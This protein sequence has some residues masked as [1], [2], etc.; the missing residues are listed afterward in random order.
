M[1]NN[2]SQ[3]KDIIESILLVSSEPVACADLEE[4]LE[5]ENK[6]L[7]A[8]ALDELENEYRLRDRGFFLQRLGD[9]VRLVTK[10]E[11]ALWIRRFLAGKPVRFSRAALETLA[12]IAYR[13]PITRP[14]IEA[15]RG[16]DASGVLR[17]LLARELIAI[18]G[19]KE[20]P[21]SPWMYVTTDKFLQVF[22][23]ASLSSLPDINSFGDLYPSLELPLLDGQ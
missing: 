16:V 19:R 23:L 11:N 13:Q 21:G 14:E 3:L 7:L 12:I 8:A 2:I 10:P 20:V 9:S 5:P 22:N 15:I 1:I 6:E 4:L 18:K 17:L